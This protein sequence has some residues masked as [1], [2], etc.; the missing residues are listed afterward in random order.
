MAGKTRRKRGGSPCLFVLEDVLVSISKLV[1][2]IQKIGDKKEVE[3]KREIKQS[4][5]NDIYIVFM[6][7]INDACSDIKPKKYEEFIKKLDELMFVIREKRD[8]IDEL[9]DVGIILTKIDDMI[10]RGTQLMERES[11]VKPSVTQN[12]SKKQKKKTKVESKNVSPKIEA[13]TKIEN[14]ISVNEGE[15]ILLPKVEVLPKAKTPPKVEVLPKAK[16]P[17]NVEVLPK[18]K[19]PPKAKTLGAPQQRPEPIALEPMN[20]RI[21]PFFT[22]FRE[23]YL[24]R[25][26]ATNIT[27]RELKLFMS[28][29]FPNVFFT[30]K[31]TTMRKTD[32][33]N[34]RHITYAYMLFIGLLNHLF[35]AVTDYA[36]NLIMSGLK[37]VFKGG[38]AAQ[39]ILPVGTRFESDDT[40]IL[41]MSSNPYHDPLFLRDIAIEIAELFRFPETTYSIGSRQ[42]PYIIKIAYMSSSGFVPIT[43]IDFKYPEY[44]QFYQ[45]IQME[46]KTW[47]NIPLIYYHQSSASFFD[48]KEYIYRIYSDPNYKSCNC[49]MIPHRP[50]C[51]QICSERQYFLDKFSKYMR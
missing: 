7:Q 25:Y 41:I 19:T 45:D 5:T 9:G 1:K 15:Q 11:M 29:I 50:E 48:E 33:Q 47:N 3:K 31:I 2:K 18:A 36:P 38:R 39:M 21:K 30:N 13:L 20:V 8:Y 10:E 49:D 35:T 40:D 28:T 42:N 34:F 46:Q 44:S 4:F 37:L 17:P 26:N 27:Y 14:T 32:S 23:N 43:D 6:S 16:T 24:L 12:K 51:T 22:W